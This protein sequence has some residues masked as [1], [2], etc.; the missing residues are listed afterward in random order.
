MEARDSHTSAI[1]KTAKFWPG[2]STSGQTRS[3][4]AS[5][6][7]VSAFICVEAVAFEAWTQ[8]GSLTATETA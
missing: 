7:A 1:L 3:G 2:V 4:S 8:H 5:I 6:R